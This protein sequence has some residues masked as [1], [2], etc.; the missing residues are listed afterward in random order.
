MQPVLPPF[1]HP[2]FAHAFILDWDGVL[3]ETHLDFSQIRSRYFQGRRV[4]LLE[5]GRF[6]PED[7]KLVICGI[8]ISKSPLRCPCL[9]G[10]S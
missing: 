6:L 1:W 5:Y 9:L 3:A 4:P 7:I 10:E 2:A 8:I